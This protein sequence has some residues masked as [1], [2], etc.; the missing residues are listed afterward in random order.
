MPSQNYWGKR[1]DELLNTLSITCKQSYT[2]RGFGY[3]NVKEVG[4]K[5]GFS[6]YLSDIYPKVFARVKKMVFN[7]LYL[8]F[9]PLST[10]I[11]INETN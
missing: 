10:P 5:T 4:G 3:L 2:G 7:L 9:S 1:G 8:V 6:D 11:T